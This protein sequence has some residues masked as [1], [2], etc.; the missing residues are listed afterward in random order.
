[1]RNA[2]NV[3]AKKSIIRAAVYGV[4]E[5][6]VCARL[7]LFR[8]KVHHV[9]FVQPIKFLLF[10]YC[11]PRPYGDCLCTYSLPYAHAAHTCTVGTFKNLFVLIRRARTVRAVRSIYEND[12]E[13]QI[14]CYHHRCVSRESYV[15]A[16]AVQRF[17][18]RATFDSHAMN[19]VREYSLSLRL[20]P[21]TAAGS[22]RRSA[23]HPRT[24]RVS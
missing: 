21:A 24:L 13:T 14:R 6:N 23:K 8:F 18:P 12:L 2:F 15:R 22:T 11:S 7:R 16:H 20:T 17:W 19:T 1:V 3:F 4:Y 9:V 10:E 5:Q